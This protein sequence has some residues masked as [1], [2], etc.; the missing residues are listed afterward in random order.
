MIVVLVHKPD[1]VVTPAL[2]PFDGISVYGIYY[3]SEHTA[4]ISMVETLM[5]EHPDWAFV[6]TSNHK[7][8]VGFNVAPRQT[9]K[10]R[11]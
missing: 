8:S 5:H 6:T 4:V 9:P 7:I 1:E 2:S 11:D 10:R 3:E